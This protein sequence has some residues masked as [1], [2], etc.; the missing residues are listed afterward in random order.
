MGHLTF[1]TGG[2]RSGKSTLAVELARKQKSRV[3]YIATAVGFDAEM[4][5][6]IKEHKRGRPENWKTFEEPEK[7]SA[8]L[9]SIEGSFDVL[10]IDCVTVYLT[11]LLVKKISVAGIEKEMY[12]TLTAIRNAQ[13]RFI[14]VSNEV[15]SGIVPAT[16]LGRKFRDLAGEANKSFAAAADRVYCMV[17]GIAQKIK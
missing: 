6:R 5:K 15:G 8:L 11:N 7:L 1:I 10:I 17:A 2:C 16:A 3:A 14:V 9:P 4:R 13:C 12:K